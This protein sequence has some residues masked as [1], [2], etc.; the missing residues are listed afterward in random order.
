MQHGAS[1]DEESRSRPK[2]A[3][4]MSKEQ[5]ERVRERERQLELKRLSRLRAKDAEWEAAEKRQQELRKRLAP[6][7]DRDVGRL[8]GA[9]TAARQRQRAIEEDRAQGI[10]HQE[11][12]FI[13]HVQKLGVPSYMR[14]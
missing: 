8:L 5:K 3:P 1:Q 12:G 9:T 2:S 4:V 6:K 7:V 13:R 11:P 10:R 14:S